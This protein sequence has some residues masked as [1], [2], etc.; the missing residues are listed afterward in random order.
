[1]SIFI[2]QNMSQ[3]GTLINNQACDTRAAAA[4][5]GL[6]EQTLR[7]LRTTGGGPPFVKLGRAVRYRP[8]DLEAWLSARLMTST[9][10]QRS[11][12]L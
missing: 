6:A 10:D 4:L 12:S 11:A 8:S 2:E 5:L 9:S 7:K 3:S 1:M